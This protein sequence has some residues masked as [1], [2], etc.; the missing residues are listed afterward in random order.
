[1]TD[2]GI[3]VTEKS[4]VHNLLDSFILPL[5]P[6]SRGPTLGATMS[7]TKS[8]VVADLYHLGLVGIPTDAWLG[9]RILVKKPS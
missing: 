8:M 6:S 2:V 3:K 7:P 4:H 5:Y 9:G 1:M